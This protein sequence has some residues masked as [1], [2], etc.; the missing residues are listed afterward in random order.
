MGATGIWSA[1]RHRIPLLV[2]IN[3]NR[4]YFNDELHQENVARTRGRE[5][6]NRWIGLRMED[7]VPNIAKLAEA[8][9][10]VGIGPVTSAAEA[11]QAIAKGVDV[12]KKGGVCVID[13]HV[14]PPAERQAS[15]S[16]GHR[17]TG[18]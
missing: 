3:N 18:A 17:A 6:R 7:P 16:L 11:G 1:A 8:Q 10:A 5:V 2:L 4:S 9:G 13:F 14:D 12:L 15:H